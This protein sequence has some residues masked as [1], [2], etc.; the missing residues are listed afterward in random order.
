MAKGWHIL[1]DGATLTLARHLPPRF[2]VAARTRLPHAGRLRTANLIRQD[3]W[4][5]LQRQKGFSPVIEIINEDTGM[6]VR[7]GGRVMA[8]PFDRS[9]LEA[10]IAAVLENAALRARWARDGR[11]FLSTVEGV[12]V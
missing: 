5:A 2:D 1:R 4:R 7:A 9:G 8:R 11:H 10:R 6:H 3:M 12:T